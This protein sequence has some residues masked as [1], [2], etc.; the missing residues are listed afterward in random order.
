MDRP[1][2][3]APAGVFFRGNRIVTLIDASVTAAAPRTLP[4]LQDMSAREIVSGIAA[5]DLSS[6]EVVEHFT[7]RLHTVNGK[8]NAVTVDLS[9]S[10]RKT[11]A[12]VDK[13]RAR[14]EKLAPLAGLPVT[15]KE[16]FDLAGTAS[17][18]GLPTRRGEIESRD[19]PYVAA[20]RTAG[21]IP[22][23][24]TNL[25]QLMI[26][27]ETHNPLYGR[28]SNPWNLERSC[29]GSS[30]G[31]GAVIA[32]GASPLGLGNDIGG[33]LRVPAA[34]CGIT[35]IRPTAGRT[36]DYCAH[37]LPVGQ[38]AIVSQVGP[39][40]R[41]V[42][43]LVMGLLV[44][45]RARDPHVVPGLEL[46]DPTAVDLSR[47]RFATFTDDGEFPVAPAARRAVAEASAMLTAAGAR[48]VA[49][50]PP[51][52][53]RATDL[54]FAAL[55]ADRAKSFRRLL[56]GNQR[57]PRVH[58]LLV[59]AGLPLWLRGVAGFA[60]DVRGQRRSARTLRRFASGSVDEYW[61]TI[62]AIADFRNELLRS[63]ETADGGPIDVV[64]CPAYAVPAVRHGATELMPISG[65]YGPIANV[66]GFPAGIVPVTRVHPGEESDRLVSRDAVDLMAREC[67]RDSAGLPIAVQV[68]AR[69]WRDHVALAA[70]AAIE[71]AAR[72]MPDYPERPPL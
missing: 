67:E 62:E 11:A 2:L 32:A 49:W 25:P 19:D 21:A 64:I 26:F 51:L 12:D 53:S 16:C 18:F 37:G 56:R 72:K 14:G 36:P 23:A 1:Y 42:E 35:S 3:G 58:S 39:L 7:A 70:M 22:I 17:T 27:A 10:A 63:F 45:D 28:T 15:I 59:A 31:E 40:A 60:F 46:G 47:L 41:R 65:A 5:G 68:I 33:S 24:K 66:S 55:S 50:K 6:L 48:A 44:L 61:Q 8:L 57:D 4:S 71:A 13:A 34:F 20:L 52:L 38:T 29:G 9:E 43:D 54:L 30:G 69:P